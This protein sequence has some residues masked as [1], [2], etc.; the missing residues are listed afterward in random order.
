M[1]DDAR[2]KREAQPDAHRHDDVQP[3]IETVIASLPSRSKKDREAL[4]QALMDGDALKP[5]T[6]PEA[7]PFF[8]NRRYLRTLFELVFADIGQWQPDCSGEVQRRGSESWYLLSV[9]NMG[10]IGLTG[11][12]W[13]ISSLIAPDVRR[14]LHSPQETGVEPGPSPRTANR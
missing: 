5:E 1:P 12:C 4:L 13:T 7:A 11:R 3:S 14:Q 8:E 9:R 6:P 10:P 2:P